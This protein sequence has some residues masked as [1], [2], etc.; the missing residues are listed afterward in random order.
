MLDGNMPP[1]ARKKNKV[2]VHDSPRV[3]GLGQLSLV[4]H[5]LCPLDQRASLSESLVYGAGYSYTD[6]HGNRCRANAKVIAPLGMTVTDEFYLWGL[7]ALANRQEASAGELIATPHWILR[8]LGVIDAKSRRGGRQYQQFSDA[9]RRLSAVTYLNDAFYDPIRSEHR[10]V[11][12]GFF[13][14]SLP[15]DPNSSRVW[16]F[17]W[18]PILIEMIQADAGHLHFDLSLYR[19]LDPGSRRLFLFVSKVFYRRRSLRAIPL[20]QLAIGTIGFSESIHARDLRMKVKRC[21]GRLVDSGVLAEASVYRTPPGNYFVHMSRG[22]RLSAS[23][24]RDSKPPQLESPML[25]V[26]RS[27]GFD[28]ASSFRL[29]HR[30]QRQPKLLAEWCDIT[31]AAMERFGPTFF[32]NSPMAFLIDSID[33]ASKGNRMPPDWWNE[34]RRSESSQDGLSNESMKIL[35]K[36]R[37]ELTQDKSLPLDRGKPSVESKHPVHTSRILTSRT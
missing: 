16:R 19:T 22:D 30:F 15:D 13:S 7:L 32:R 4:E 9:I 37:A 2:I 25:E 26:L 27:I 35:D 24:C 3:I 11:S 1:R 10:R 21:L 23:S 18:D 29:I 6:Q 14:Y 28:D 8:Q 17:A 33:K 5:A 34:L 12:F 36:I 20:S 31:Q